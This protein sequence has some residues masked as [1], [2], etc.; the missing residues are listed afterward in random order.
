MAIPFT[1]KRLVAQ[2]IEIGT[3][4]LVRGT[5]YASSP[6]T[7]NPI[8][9]EAKQLS[10]GSVVLF[11][12]DTDVQVSLVSGVVIYPLQLSADKSTASPIPM[13]AIPAS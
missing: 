10:D 1:F 2:S 4:P 5:F 8:I 12:E 7:D 13:S 11:R 6:D 9:Y 3:D